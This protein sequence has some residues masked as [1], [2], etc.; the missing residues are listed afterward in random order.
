MH[1]PVAVSHNLMVL[2]AEPLARRPSRS[3]ARDRTDPRCPIS[4]RIGT[5]V[6][7]FTISIRSKHVN[8]TDPSGSDTVS[9]MGGRNSRLCTRDPLFHILNSPLLHPLASN[10]RETAASDITSPLPDLKLCV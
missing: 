1:A 8:A 7:G 5:K 6:I 10:P 4:V 9:N 3:T 2:S